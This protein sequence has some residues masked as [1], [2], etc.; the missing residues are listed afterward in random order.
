VALRHLCR[1][2]DPLQD[3]LAVR[4]MAMA[5]RRLGPDVVSAHTAKAGCIA[6]LAC[7]RSG[8][9]V[10]YT[11]HGWAITDRISR[12]QGSIYRVVERCT[13]PLASVIVNVCQYE[14][15]L[16]RKHRIGAEDQHTVVYNGMPDVPQALRATPGGGPPRL[17]MVAR[18]EAP[19]DHLTLVEALS[20]LREQPWSLDLVGDGPLQDAVRARVAELGLSDRVR[21][22]GACGNVAEILAASQIFVLSTRSEAFPRSILEAM[23]AGLP[24]VAS[25]VGGVNEAVLDGRSG[26]VVARQS[27][28]ALRGALGW[29]IADAGTRVRFGAAG[30]R[31]YE[32]RFTFDRMLAETMAIYEHVTGI[33]C[34]PVQAAEQVAGNRS[35]TAAAPKTA[36]ADQ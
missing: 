16:A 5:I 35:L 4:E 2:V 22:A 14:Y 13:A 6:R 36:E 12:R 24:V 7:C 34:T 25:D 21:F 26:Y 3:L 28:S 33:P 29:L 18:F 20:G 8:V 17:V 30:R 10:L 31:E 15:R 11:P 27:V 23:R 19:K 9:P 1:N 32:Q